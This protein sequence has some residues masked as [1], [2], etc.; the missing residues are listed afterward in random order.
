MNRTEAAPKGTTYLLTPPL[1]FLLQTT[2]QI[3][4]MDNLKL[5][6]YHACGNQS[7]HDIKD[8]CSGNI[9]A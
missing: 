3:T 2:S 9:D 1:D 7:A 8:F 5:H 4:T 6:N